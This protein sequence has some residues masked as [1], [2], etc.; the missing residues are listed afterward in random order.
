MALDRSSPKV[1]ACET[2]RAEVLEI[3]NAQD[4]NDPESKSDP[5]VIADYLRRV[6][7]GGRGSRSSAHY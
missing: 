7:G 5:G 2:D 3:P 1:N 6:G 4:W